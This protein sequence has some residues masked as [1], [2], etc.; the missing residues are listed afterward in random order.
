VWISLV[1]EALA[2]DD[3]ELFEFRHDVHLELVGGQELRGELLYTL[4]PEHA[5]VAD[6]LNTSD[7]F[8]RLWSGGRLYLVNKSFVERVVEEPLDL[9]ADGDERKE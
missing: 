6:Y 5:R 1:P 9:A 3:D 2:E 8:A 4:P 7:R